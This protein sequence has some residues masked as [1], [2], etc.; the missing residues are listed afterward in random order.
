MPAP[1]HHISGNPSASPVAAALLGQWAAK[2]ARTAA[3][4]LRRQAL[5][6]FADSCQLGAMLRC[7][8]VGGWG[9]KLGGWAVTLG[10]YG[11]H[12]QGRADACTQQGSV[13][14]M[15]EAEELHAM[16]AATPC[17][18]VNVKCLLLLCRCAS[19]CAQL[20]K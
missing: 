1:S 9:G 11:N 16:A 7:V 12:S 13:Q 18:F 20:W 5:T 15:H 10:R 3:R 8:E 14:V 6:P 17:S 4:T 19:C 2:E